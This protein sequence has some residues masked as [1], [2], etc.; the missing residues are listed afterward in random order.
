MVKRRLVKELK[1]YLILDKISPRLRGIVSV[2]LITTG[3]LLQLNT[4]NIVSGMPFMILCL[5]LNLIKGVSVKEVTPGQLK[6]QEV[7]PEKVKQV[8]AHCRRIKKFRSHNL[9]CFIGLLISIFVLGSFLFPLFS[10]L[11]VPFPLTATI[12]N[13][14]ILFSGLMLSGR[15]SAWMPLALDIKAE[16]VKRIIELPAVKNDP[17]LQVM[18][19]FEIGQAEQGSF[20][21][22]TRVLIKFREA[23]EEFI[24]LQGQISINMV[25]S[26]KYPYFYIV[27]LARPAFGLFDKFKSLKVSLDKVTIEQK[28]AGEVDV[29]VMRQHTAKTSGYHTSRKAQDYILQNGIRI[30]KELI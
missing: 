22:D 11:S 15:K 29:I 30:V 8:L 23:P 13:A 18:P 17:S 4:R 9:G 26:K 16:I 19:Y 20:P 1:T 10:E 3:F 27:L 14:V 28:K 21:N 6:W 12:V 7:T 25:K 2:F 5:I 24:G